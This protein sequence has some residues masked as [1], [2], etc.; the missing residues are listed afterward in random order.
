MDKT[1]LITGGSSGIGL[2]TAQAFGEAGWRVYTLSRNPAKT[3]SVLHLRAD[4]TDEAAVRSAIETVVSRE[5]RLDVL[6]NCAGFGISGAAEFTD[7]ADARRQFDVNFFGVVNVC[8]AALPILR[9]QGG[10]RIINVSSVAA[11]VAIPFQS[12]YSASKAAINSYTCALANE[13]RSFGISVTA[14]QP[15]DIRTGFT[16]ARKKAVTGDDVY[17]GRISRSVSRMERDEEGGMEPSRVGSFLRAIA[18]KRRVKPLYTVGFSYR[19]VCL[20]C[21]I[22]PCGVLNR[23]VFWLYAK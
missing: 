22:L 14:V 6:V 7:A 18:R 21:K 13:V 19:C 8:K 15:G 3:P 2:A 20:L 16:A 10:G 5:G 12:F 1:V 17:G 11:P 23:I 4:V 9:A